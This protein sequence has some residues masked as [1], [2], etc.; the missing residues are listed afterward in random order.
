MLRIHPLR[1]PPFSETNAA[2]EFG[3]WVSVDAESV[4]AAPAG[5]HMRA[6]GNSEKLGD[7]IGVPGRGGERDE[8]GIWGEVVGHSVVI[9]GV[10]DF[11]RKEEDLRGVE[12]EAV[13]HVPGEERLEG[14]GGVVVM[15]VAGFFPGEH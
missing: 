1:Y 11:V 8:P 6:G 3:P 14:G 2:G 10:V 9:R 15:P 12:D 5:P 7:G 13:R 4:V